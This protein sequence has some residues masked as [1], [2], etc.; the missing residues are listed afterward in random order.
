[1]ERNRTE[2][3]ET[4]LCNVAV[5]YRALFSSSVL[6]DFGKVF[7]TRTV[8]MHVYISTTNHSLYGSAN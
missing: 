5:P 7:L 1:M 2:Q 8:Y 4:S 3:N 6:N